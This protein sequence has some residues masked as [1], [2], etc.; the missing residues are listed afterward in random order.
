PSEIMYDSKPHIGTDELQKVIVNMRNDL[1]KM[2]C[3][4]EFDTLIDDVEIENEKCVGIK[5][6]NRKFQ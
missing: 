3:E 6:H 1:I 4:F 5:S 2:G